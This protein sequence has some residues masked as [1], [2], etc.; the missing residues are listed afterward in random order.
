[1]RVVRVILGLILGFVALANGAF[2]TETLFGDSF[3]LGLAAMGFSVVVYVAGVSTFLQI[4]P[5]AV[6][7][8]RR[9]A[10]ASLSM[11]TL[12]AGA[13]ALAIVVQAGRGPGP[14]FTWMVPF[15]FGVLVC[16]ILL[17]P[18]ALWK[19]V[20]LQEWTETPPPLRID[21]PYD[22]PE[23]PEDMVVPDPGPT[24]LA[25]LARKR[26]LNLSRAH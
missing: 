10:L 25:L 6:R 17:A 20:T 2:W 4:S 1:M 15:Y 24:L 5:G 23:P 22:P 8:A 14:E 13:A 11:A 18:I 9:V 19:A 26:S 3:T 21:D 12:I 7:I 16:A